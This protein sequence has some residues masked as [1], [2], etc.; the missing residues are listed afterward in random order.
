MIVA[1]RAVLKQ[2]GLLV[3]ARRVCAGTALVAGPIGASTD[4]A[5]GSDAFSGVMAWDDHSGLGP[6][7]EYDPEHSQGRRL[8]V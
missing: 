3:V 1:R 6:T 4:A 5:S 2:V 7:P 8:P